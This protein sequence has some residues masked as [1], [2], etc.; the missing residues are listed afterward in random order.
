VGPVEEYV[1]LARELGRMKKKI[2]GI[3]SCAISSKTVRSDISKAEGPEGYRNQNGD[4][5][6]RYY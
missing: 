5:N 6:H 2:N 1:T 3:K 4:K